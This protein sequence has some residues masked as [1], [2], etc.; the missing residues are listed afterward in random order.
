MQVKTVI[1][2]HILLLGK[3]LPGCRPPRRSGLVF[4]ARTHADMQVAGLEAFVD[5]RN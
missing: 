5:R 2:G 4:E 3:R 1:E